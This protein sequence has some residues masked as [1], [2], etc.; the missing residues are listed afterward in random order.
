[1]IASLRTGDTA[2]T[3]PTENFWLI[4]GVGTSVMHA[5]SNG[6]AIEHKTTTVDKRGRLGLLGNCG[7]FSFQ[8]KA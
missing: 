4:T 2:T 1:M 8:T 3:A 5:S 6:L 7:N